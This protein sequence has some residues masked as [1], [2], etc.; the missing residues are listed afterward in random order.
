MK[1][2]GFR[3]LIVMILIISSCGR[4]FKIP[5]QDCACIGQKVGGSINL[6]VFQNGFNIAADQV[7]LIDPFTNILIAYGKPQSIPQ[8]NGSGST[9]TFDHFSDLFDSGAAQEFLSQ[10]NSPRSFKAIATSNNVVIGT[11]NFRLMRNC[12]QII[13]VDGKMDIFIP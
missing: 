12:C 9:F 4:P 8:F 7:Q 5:Q 6:R 13:L 3:I 1:K 2:F 11:S 10:G